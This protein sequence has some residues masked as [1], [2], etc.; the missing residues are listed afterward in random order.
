MVKLPH[1]SYIY[2][3]YIENIFHCRISYELLYPLVIKYG[4]VENPPFGGC[5]SQPCL[6]MAGYSTPWKSPRNGQGK[7]YGFIT[8][9]KLEEAGKLVGYQPLVLVG[10]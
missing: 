4:L 9:K 1:L 8:F 2:I 5:P 3:Y 6:T 7:G 10:A